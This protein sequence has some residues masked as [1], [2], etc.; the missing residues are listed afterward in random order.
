MRNFCQASG[1]NYDP[2]WRSGWSVATDLSLS[3]I[4]DVVFTRKHDDALKTA[5][6]AAKTP[7]DA[8]EMSTLAAGMETSSSTLK[9]RSV[10]SRLPQLVQ[11]QGLSRLLQL[12]QTRMSRSLC[13]LSSRASWEARSSLMK[14]SSNTCRMQR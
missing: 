3:F 11:H 10:P 5:L 4:E 14:R 12:A 8:L 2:Q 13:P 9:S 1:E 6:R 7:E